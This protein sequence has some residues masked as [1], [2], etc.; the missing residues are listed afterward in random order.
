LAS[1]ASRVFPR[2]YAI[3]AGDDLTF[4]LASAQDLGF[5]QI[6]VRPPRSDPEI[7]DSRQGCTASLVD[8]VRPT[9]LD[10]WL[11]LT[12]HE[13]PL[14]HPVVAEHPGAF[15]VRRAIAG[16]PVDPRWAPAPRGRAIARFDQPEADSL[17][18]WWIDRIRSL[19][20]MGV[21]GF[22]ANRPDAVPA[23][24]WRRLIAASKADG[25]HI[26]FIAGPFRAAAA[27]PPAFEGTNFDYCLSSLYRWDGRASW[28]V[29]EHAVLARIAPV[30]AVVAREDFAWPATVRERVRRVRL[31]CATGDGMVMPA[32]YE[33]VAGQDGAGLTAAIRDVNG[34]FA[35]EPVLS[36]PG[37]LRSLTGP[38]SPMTA[39]LRASPARDGGQALLALV[40]PGG[41]PVAA[42]EASLVAAAQAD[43]DRVRLVA[44]GGPDRLLQPREVR[45]L[46][47]APARPV[48]VPIRRRNDEAEI[49]AA[50][51]RVIIANVSPEVDEGADAVKRIVG[52]ELVV[53]ADV[54]TDGHE[55]LAAEL[56]FRAQDD[57]DWSRLP[58]AP[59][60]NDRW[61]GRVLLKRPGRHAFA[62]AAWIDHWGG[63]I[64]DLGKKRDAGLDL[65]LEVQE[66]IALVRKVK[67]EA[68][69]CVGSQ[70][71]V[72]L[73]RIE[74]ADCAGRIELLLA[75]ELRR[76]MAEAGSRPF[77]VESFT[78][79]VE[80]E[81]SAAR[82]ASWYE[83]FPRSTT[84]DPA[85]PGRLLDVIDR[86]P[87]I[88]RM[89][90]DVLYFPPIH[91]IG[92]TNRKGRNNALR[93]EPGDPGSPYA[94]GAEA[95]GHDAIAPELGTLEDFRTLLAAARGHGI[96]IA[97]DFA[98]QCSPDHPWLREHPEWFAWRPD[99][100]MKYAENPPKKYE[101]IVNV[102][103]YAPE[104]LPGLWLALRDIVLFW[105]AQGV[106]IFRVDNPHTKPLPFWRW[107]IAEVR[108]A[109]PDVIFLAEAF[110]RPKLM[111]HLAKIGFSQSYTYFTWR[112]TKREFTEYLTELNESNAREFFRPHF[113]V[114]TPDINPYFL[115]RSGR[116]GFLIR[117]ALAATLSGL[118]GI[119]SGFEL[120]E[121]EPLPGREEY[122]DSEKYQIR[123]RN[124]DQPGN[125]VAEITRLNW[126]RKAEPAL[127]SHL[128]VTFY[129]AF[130]D[131]ILYFG[132]SAPGQSDKI[133]VAISLDPDQP[134]EA[135]F[136]VPLWEWGLPDDA[137]VDAVDLLRDAPSVWRG[138][139][140]HVRLTPD[141]PYAIWRAQPRSEA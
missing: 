41:D 55:Q 78:Q 99:G 119:Y 25:R 30:L 54:F 1:P 85:R 95:G 123:P 62:V 21:Q 13:L 81:R 39:L 97:L 46:A 84:D 100:S 105:V 71:A 47:I 7:A 139:I 77:R 8:S 73:A 60:T 49:A 126:L 6:L 133:L 87:A 82:F 18:T 72:A 28:L 120:C 5:R 52:D 9:G 138:K 104:A 79:P 88:A 115:Q 130:D 118:W 44:G 136:E 4:S 125:I 58:M 20:E 122:R 141:A 15:G 101:D 27:N 127:Q 2:V 76:L 107:M 17:V 53:E 90:F 22:L 111:Y 33:A 94:I 109:H 93:A 40:N 50:V 112:H 68:G 108:G 69:G 63:F 98:I 96:E 23:A 34:L 132:K 57:L 116:P 134:R 56:L 92:R 140:Q 64:R 106:R 42:A 12:I 117:A 74:A 35:N 89:G 137:E 24:V 14:D 19:A 102:D 128:G 135:D 103:F 31:A 91:P 110:T 38:G 16:G 114:N 51:A 86:L 43:A 3:T 129:N 113:F 83:L 67:A 124:W 75:P 26:D 29:E 11:E 45:L 36:R 65:T 70:L 59:L 131:R 121:A 66:G 32:G 80:V 48:I 10:I 61:Q 37:A